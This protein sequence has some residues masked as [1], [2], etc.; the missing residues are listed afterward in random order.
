MTPPEKTATE[1]VC[2]VD[3][4]LAILKSIGRLLASDGLSVRAFS[5]PQD[6]LGYAHIHLVPLVVL[7]IL[8]EGMTGL[9]V[10]AQLRELSPR[11]RVIIMTGREGPTTRSAATDMGA[12]AFFT[13][14]FDD[15]QFLRAVHSALKEHTQNE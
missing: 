3:D 14:P 12:S 1:V 8:M 7:D 5:R 10:Q 13:K 11:T 15:E 2:L 6:F 9:E 4:D